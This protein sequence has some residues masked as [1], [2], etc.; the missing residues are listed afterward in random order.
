ML[1]DCLESFCGVTEWLLDMRTRPGVGYAIVYDIL[2]SVFDEM[3]ISLKYSDLYDAKTRLKELFDAYSELG[4]W[5]FTETKEDMIITSTVW[6][7]PIGDKRRGGRIKMGEGQA[8]KKGDAQQRAA[9]RGL[10]FLKRKG[11]EK[12]PPEEYFLFCR[13]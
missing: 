11:F 8:A 4:T 5:V 1:E 7:V 12:A 3:N 2:K 10:E 13:Y 6:R 9:T